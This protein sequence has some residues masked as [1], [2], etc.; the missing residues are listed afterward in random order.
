[1]CETWGKDETDF[2]NC[3]PGYTFFAYIRQKVNQAWRNSG[4]VT[5][6]I[7]DKYIVNGTIKRIFEQ[8]SEC[9]VLL[10]DGPKIGHTNDIV[11]F[12][13][14]V[15]PQYSPVYSEDNPDG[16]KILNEKLLQIIG[17]LPDVDLILAG[18]LNARTKLFQDF[19]PNDNLNFVFGEGNMYPEDNF[20]IP[21]NSKDSKTHNSFGISLI[22]MCCS[23]DIHMFNGRLGRDTQGEFTC[24]TNNGASTVDYMIGSS[25][26]FK[27]V[28][29]FGIS[30][31]SFSVHC[32]VYCRLSFPKSTE[33]H[34][35]VDDCDLHPYAK[36]RW[37][38]KLKTKFLDDFKNRY[39]LFERTLTTSG[40]S[41]VNFLTQF[42]EIIKD[43]G[44]CMM[45]KNQTNK[46]DNR[47]KQPP[48]WNNECQKLKADKYHRLKLFRISNDWFDL[49]RFKQAKNH[50]KCFCKSR[51]IQYQRDCRKRLVESRNDP[52]TF[53]TS[54]KQSM[55]NE[56]TSDEHILK[57]DWSKYFKTLLNPVT[58][59]QNE[60]PPLVEHGGG[61][62]D[63]SSL[64]I[65]ITEEEIKNS[66]SKLRNNKSPG[67]DGIC[68]EIYKSTIETILPYLVQLFNEI[69]DTGNFPSEWSE[70]IITPIHKKGP[71]SD[72][73][74]YRGISLINSLGK[75]FVSV[76]NSRLQHF[77]D[78]HELIDESQAGFRKDYSTTDN[79]FTLCALAQKYL[80]K[81]GGRFYCIFIDFAKAFDCIKHYRLW[82]TFIQYGINGKFLNIFKSMYK[83]L[84]S[85]VKTRH[86]LTEFFSC[87]IGTRQGCIS[88]PLIFS[89]FINDLVLFLRQECDR[90]IFVSNDIPDL[91]A[92]LF[93]DDVSSFGET[94]NRL[95]RQINLIANFCDSI[96]MSVNLSKTKIVVFRN[97]GCLRAYEKWF[98]KGDPIEVV[99][100][101]KYLG[102]YMTPKLIWSK[103]HE[104]AA[105]Q[106]L[107]VT[108]CIFKYQ[109]KFGYFYP[110]DIFKLFDSM[111]KPILCY[112]C[113]I[114]GY[115]YIERI[116]K[117]HIQFL[118]RYCKLP[119]N[120]A[121]IFVYGECGRLPLCVTYF[122]RCIKYWTKLITMNRSRYPYQTY[123]ML[124]NLDE[125]GRTTWASQI[126]FLLNSNGFGYAWISQEVGNINLFIQTFKQ[127]V[128]DG[129]IQKWS[130]KL[131]NSSKADTYRGFKSLLNIERYLYT[132]MPNSL[133]ATLARFRC[134]C[135]ELLIEKGRHINIDR[136]HRYCPICIK[137][138]I[139]VVE[140]EFHF[141]L[142]CPLY[143]GLRMKYLRPFFAL[144]RNINVFNNIFSNTDDNVIRSVAKFIYEAFLIRNSELSL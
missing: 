82:A 37:S 58:N 53:W 89:L 95:Q 22:E 40:E 65:P 122:T 91:F 32:P 94:C 4:G 64:N 121:D 44:K 24:F 41:R 10:L 68:I 112:G 67:P 120:A 39:Q 17:A 125:C 51:K 13:T 19:I 101:Y 52:K 93:A 92:L 11:L 128:I 74:N 59:A 134:S 124:Y 29:D 76:L 141:F 119:Q 49:E 98:Y 56:C 12:F 31:I 77:C 137:N 97:G 50:F 73:G 123:K 71:K 3:L 21:R 132:D 46:N 83:Q 6:F 140:T 23:L 138:N 35:E 47:Y 86:G 87:G 70:S 72:P 139:H 7:R 55:N 85:C 42:T 45:V 78:E 104:C 54:I 118:K 113:E 130:T 28:D 127:R 108:A 2:E 63:C 84:K 60:H 81:P 144:F 27:Y 48:W 36:I 30:D 114:W 105:N 26:I 100:F 20:D 117:V 34:D 88:S 66:L 9:V 102:M 69:L 136:E 1:M 116:E 33:R 109:Y 14:Y 38:E 103:T 107:K 133:K 16:I 43:T 15:S 126:R 80:S 5:V 57:N 106:A 135:H 110:D 75:I 129:C 90:G 143:E 25:S 61:V 79:I 18:D 99:P 8:M 62:I 131:T 115:Q 96:E 111:V 142:E